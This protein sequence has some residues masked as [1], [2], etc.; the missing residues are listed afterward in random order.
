MNLVYNLNNLK[1]NV[2]RLKLKAIYSDWNSRSLPRGLL[3]TLL[4]ADSY[5]VLKTTFN[6]I[7]ECLLKRKTV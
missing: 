5:A 1:R 2:L 4:N 7:D 3:S 6:S